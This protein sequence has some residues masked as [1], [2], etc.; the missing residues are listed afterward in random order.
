MGAESSMQSSPWSFYLLPASTPAGA[1]VSIQLAEPQSLH[2]WAGFSLFCHGRQKQSTISSK[3]WKKNINTKL[4]AVVYLKSHEIRILQ[5]GSQTPCLCKHQHSLMPTPSG[6][7]H[8]GVDWSSAAC[9]HGCVHGTFRA[10]THCDLLRPFRDRAFR[11]HVTRMSSIPRPQESCHGDKDIWDT[12]PSKSHC[13]D[14]WSQSL[15]FQGS[16]LPQ[17]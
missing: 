9:T 11:A 16:P 12:P 6:E 2:T 8:Q 17:S 7:D 10:S 3:K 14:S 5:I 1:L 13:W 15:E 4:R